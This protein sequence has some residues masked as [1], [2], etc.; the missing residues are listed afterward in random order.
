MAIKKEAGKAF[1]VIFPNSLLEEIDTICAN[2]YISRTSWLLRAAKQF[3]EKE[4]A[5]RTEE[6]LAKI[7]SKE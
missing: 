3:L 2:Q 6:I 7:A 1:S 4:R 5:D